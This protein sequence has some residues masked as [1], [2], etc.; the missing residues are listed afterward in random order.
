MKEG[1]R[2][3]LYEEQNIKNKN[4]LN[5]ENKIGTSRAVLE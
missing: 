2:D 1:R 3:R 5:K 4:H